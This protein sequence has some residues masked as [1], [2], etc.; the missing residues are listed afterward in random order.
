MR[1]IPFQ[2]AAMNGTEPS[3]SAVAGLEDDLRERRV[4]VLLVNAQISNAATT[5]LL[6]IATEAAVPAIG[7][8]ET[9]P[10][11]VDYTAWMMAELDCLQAALEVAT[12]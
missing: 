3:A 11:G 9:Q 7:V 1:D 8:T 2:L 4:R 10:A 12:P 5:R 6:D